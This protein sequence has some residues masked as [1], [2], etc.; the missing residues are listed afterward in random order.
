[1]KKLNE[2]DVSASPNLSMTD[3][4]KWGLFVDGIMIFFSS[5]KDAVSDF[6]DSLNRS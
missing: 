5:N 2:S 6:K 3:L 1:M 4:N